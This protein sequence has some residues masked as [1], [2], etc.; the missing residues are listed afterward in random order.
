M[1][2]SSQRFTYS[3]SNDVSFFTPKKKQQPKVAAHLSRPRSLVVVASL[4]YSC[5]DATAKQTNKQKAEGKKK[6]S[7]APHRKKKE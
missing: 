6:K 7:F 2:L 4:Y 5:N 3:Y 1:G